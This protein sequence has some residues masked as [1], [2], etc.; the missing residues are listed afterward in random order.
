MLMRRRNRSIWCKTRDSAI[1]HRKWTGQNWNTKKS[2]RRTAWVTAS[3]W[4]TWL[5]SSMCCCFVLCGYRPCKLQK[6]VMTE[7][8]G[9]TGPEAPYDR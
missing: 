9:T 5:C 2:R 6:L 4:G 3:H 8:P 1:T 7:G